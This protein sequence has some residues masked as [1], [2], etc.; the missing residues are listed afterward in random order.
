MGGFMGAGKDARRY[1]GRGNGFATLKHW[2]N[3]TVNL[4]D[5]GEWNSVYNMIKMVE[6]FTFEDYFLT[7]QGYFLRQHMIYPG[8]KDEYYNDTDIP[9]VLR[10]SLGTV[11]YR[12]YFDNKYNEMK[13]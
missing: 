3:Q 5:V 9:K 6:N 11:G 2:T 12:K 13:D 1:F 8:T 4:I 10:D 7:S